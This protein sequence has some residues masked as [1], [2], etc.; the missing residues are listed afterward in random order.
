MTDYILFKDLDGKYLTLPEALEVNKIDP[1]EKGESAVDEN[2]AK[3]EAEVVDENGAALTG[4]SEEDAADGTAKAASDEDAEVEA[5]EESKDKTIYYV[6][7]EQQQGQYIRMFRTAKMQAFILNHGIDQPFISQLEAKNEGIHFA[8]IDADVDAALKGRTGKKAAEELKAEAEKLLPL[9]RKALKKE[10]LQV[11]LENL[12][13]RKTAA[14]LTVDEQSRRM[15]DMMKMYAADGMGFGGFGNEGET[16]VL[17]AKHPLVQ[18]ITSNEENDNAKLIYKQLYDLAKLQNAP[19]SPEEMTAFV[20]R[21]NEIML[22][23]TK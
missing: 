10:Q 22:S 23:L 6:T 12:K 18:Y 9:I 16:L 4:R 19:L 5:E 2:G 1:D 15:Q 8:R 13:D 3:V 20:N 7:D 17:N 21:T 14:I 11:K